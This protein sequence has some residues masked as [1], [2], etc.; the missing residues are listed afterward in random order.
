LK[1]IEFYWDAGAFKSKED[2]LRVCEELNLLFVRINKQA[3]LNVKFD[4]NNKPAS[5]ENNYSLYHSDVMIGNNC[6]MSQM[7]GLKAAYISYHTFNVMITTNPGFCNE[8]DL[9][10]KNLIRKSNLISGVGEKQR[11]RY[12]R[13]MDE[14]LKKLIGKIE[15]D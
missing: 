5:S 3:E 12:F 2:A 13:H 11:Y 15:N 8:T 14:A 4:T 9:W 7:A 10:L 6:V 1:Q